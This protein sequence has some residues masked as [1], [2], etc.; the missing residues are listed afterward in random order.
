MIANLRQQQVYLQKMIDTEKGKKKKDSGK[1][2]DWQ[3][4]KQEIDRQ[5]TDIFDDLRTKIAGTDAKTLADQLG[6]ALE[7]AFNRGESAALTYE[8]TIDG[9]MSNAVKSAL[10]QRILE[11]P[12]KKLVDDMINK[13]GFGVKEEDS[14]VLK[15]INRK[16]AEFN[17]LKKR[18]GDKKN[19]FNA[20]AYSKLLEQKH[21]ELE[22]LKRAYEDSRKINLQGSFDGL[23]P[24]ERAEIKKKGQ[25]AMTRYTDALKQYEDL[26]G[27]ASGHSESLKGAYKTLTEETGSV[28]VGQH[29]AI[30]I[31]TGEIAKNSGFS[32]ETMRNAVGV[33]LRIEQNTAN[34]YQM[35]KDLSELNSKVSGGN[36]LRASGL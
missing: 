33:L 1:I 19:A 10:K 4:Q 6:D 29:N 13:M 2:A 7:D 5:I 9:V 8:K 24:E 18:L 31:N 16:E 12:M 15:E 14:A 26:F 28:L 22:Q 27:S 30:R 35:K 36:G 23:T 21:T 25:D 17:E 3:N 32:L 20:S 34:L 11:E